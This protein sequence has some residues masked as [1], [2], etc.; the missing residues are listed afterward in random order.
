MA[1]SINNYLR[2]LSYNYYLRNNSTEDEKI[3]TYLNNLL[4][5]LDKELGTLINRRLVFGSYD[6][7]TI[8]PRSIDS[9]SDVDLMVI[10]NHT[11]YERTPETYRTWLK[12]F[13]DK[14][15]KDRYGSEVVKSYPTVTIKLNNINYDLVPAKET[16]LFFFGKSLYIPGNGNDWIETNPNDVKDKLTEVNTKYNSIVRPIIRLLKAWNSSNEH[17][18]ESYLLEKDIIERNFSGDNIQSGLTYAS[19]RIGIINTYNQ[20]TKVE[21]LNYN[22][23]KMVESLNN[24]DLVT[25]KR[26]LHRVFPYA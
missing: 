11:E 22:L 19:G 21:S 10:F 1:V 26:W 9:K 5:N 13:A 14:Y 4:S 15:Y 20:R 2:T 6:R 24:E 23:D 25:A 7:G 17:P 16:E 3:K 8:L 12:N 18:L